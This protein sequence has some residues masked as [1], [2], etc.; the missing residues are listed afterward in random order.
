L[1]HGK[2]AITKSFSRGPI[3]GKRIPFHNK[4]REQKQTTVPGK[5]GNSAHGYVLFSAAG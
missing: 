1:R 3:L 5:R 4:K 2:I